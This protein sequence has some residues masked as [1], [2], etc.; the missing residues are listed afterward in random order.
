V[1]LDPGKISEEVGSTWRSSPLIV[2]SQILIIVLLG[3]FGYD[4]VQQRQTITAFVN[5]FIANERAQ[6]TIIN[7]QLEKLRA[8]L[9][10][11]YKRDNGS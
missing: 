2:G 11:C 9:V 6:T 3:F 5:D 8:D 10:E 7:A 1:S 4:R